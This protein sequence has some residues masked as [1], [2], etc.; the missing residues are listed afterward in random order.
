MSAGTKKNILVVGSG[1]IGLCSASYLL[2]DGHSV[3]IVERDPLGD[4]AS[5]GN[6]GAIAATEIVP[7]ALPGLWKDVP[8]WLLDPLGPL[9]LRL[10]Y[11]PKFL[12]WLYLFLKSS[13]HQQVEK[14]ASAMS[15][16]LKTAF[17]DY[18]PLLGEAGL[19]SL[20]KTEGS[21]TVY[22]S[23]KGREKD[24]Y[25]WDLTR[26]NGIEAHN[27][28][29]SEIL[30]REPQLG[31]LA[32]C[33]V[34]T[35]HWG[36]FANPADLIKGLAEQFTRN[37]G[38]YITDEIEHI[39]HQDNR[40]SSAITKSGQN[41]AFDQL[42][43]CAGAWSA[44]LAKKLGDSFPLDTERGYNTTLPTP[45]IDLNNMVLFAEDKFVAT[46]M[47][48]GLRI[49]GAVEFAGIE[50]EPNY[51]RCDALLT[52]AQNY[53][54]NLNG[55]GGTKWMGRRPSTP[56]SVPVISQSSQH[57]NVHYAFGH[58]HLGITG[59]A[60]TGRTVADM[61]SGRSASFDLNPF[62]INRF[63]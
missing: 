48:I 4:G 52:L 22:K 30:E 19:Q 10:T 57:T 50:A 46:P 63:N 38:T 11:L 29:R 61:V 37:G 43:I 8:G 45:G 20:L 39:E 51:K 41:I 3:T 7:F 32:K 13:S 59:G 35:P 34:Y 54:P 40:P 62:S 16:Y 23:E 5:C 56:D 55:A 28:S 17:D 36:H 15:A 27:L 26:R 42:V 49:G 47:N 6:A 24:S 25:Y 31:E 18:A 9:S 60:V 21:L 14:T 58:G 44:R 33:G 2:K 53:M 1:I 12:P